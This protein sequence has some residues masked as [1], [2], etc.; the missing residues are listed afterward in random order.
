LVVLVAAA[1]LTAPA[2]VGGLARPGPAADPLVQ[3]GGVMPPWTLT[4]TEG[5]RTTSAETAGRVVV[6]VFWATWYPS[7]S[8]VLGVAERVHRATRDRGVT[9]LAVSA[10]DRGDPAKVRAELGLTVRVTPRGGGGDELQRALGLLQLPGI[11]V[12]GRD[13]RVAWLKVG[14]TPGKGQ[15]LEKLLAAEIDRALA[16]GNGHPPG[17][18]PA[19]PPGQPPGQAPAQPPALPATPPTSG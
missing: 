13:G 14:H 8:E 5:R 2:P 9:V 17:A 18:P 11:Y 16:P 1:V 15:E 4:D 3:I 19:Q 6:M 7:A 12:V 10:M